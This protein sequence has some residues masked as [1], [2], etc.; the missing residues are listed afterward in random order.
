MKCTFY[1]AILFHC[2][3]CSVL[4]GHMKGGTIITFSAYSPR[5]EKSSLCPS[6]KISGRFKTSRAELILYMAVQ[7]PPFFP[8]EA[9]PCSFH[10]NT[11][12]GYRWAGFDEE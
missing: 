1:I 11:G 12:Q 10:K 7:R 8:A 4:Y 2:I 3:R 5:H 6:T 9:A